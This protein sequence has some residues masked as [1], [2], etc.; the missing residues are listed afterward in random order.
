M[1]KQNPNISTLAVFIFALAA[2][3]FIVSCVAV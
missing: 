2:I 3:F 1:P